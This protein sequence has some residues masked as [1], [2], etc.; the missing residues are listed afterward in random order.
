MLITLRE[1]AE[2]HSKDPRTLRAKAANGGFQTA[3]KIGRDWL[4]DEN[5]PCV[6]GRLRTGKYVG[7][8]K[9]K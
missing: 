4:I 3:V 2:K 8:R 5:E 7:W 1:Y 9:P 6:D